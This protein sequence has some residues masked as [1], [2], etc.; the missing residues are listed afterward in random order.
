M[1][2]L[3]GTGAQWSALDQILPSSDPP[4][5]GWRRPAPGPNE[6]RADLI[7]AVA[8]ATAAV[9]TMP[10]YPWAGL[11][12]P[13][14]APLWLELLWSVAVTLP[15][16]WRRR[17]PTVI[18]IVVSAVYMAGGIAFG[19]ALFFPMIALFVAF[20]TLG[21]W[22][23]DRQRARWTRIA[24]TAAMFI[25]LIISIFV[26]ATGHRAHEPAASGPFSP[27][28]SVVLIQLFSNATF[29]LGSY[30]LGNRGY[31][32]AIDQDALERRTAELAKERE[33]STS[34]A[35]ALERIWLAREL[36][37]VVAHH[38]SVMGV[39]ASAARVAFDQNPSVA[40]QS[41]THIETSAR[42]AVEELHGLLST[43]RDAAADVS[44]HDPGPEPDT[45]AAA[46]VGIRQLP[47]LVEQAEAA[48]LPTRLE[49]I[50]DQAGLSA[51]LDVN[52]YRIVQ[53]ALTNVRKHAGPRAT[54][55]VR[56]RFYPDEVEVE[57]TN[58][59]AV[60]PPR[61]PRPGAGLGQVGMRERVA[62]SGGTIELGA[63]ARGGYLVR[64]RMPRSAAGIVSGVG[65]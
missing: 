30:Y 44:D 16:G 29:F 21:A 2:G 27:L 48:G 1:S 52:V 3:T 8:L 6:L 38:V 14:Q 59:G 4:Y 61:R 43:L 58:S 39:Q 31:A 11:V 10:L 65:S 32:Q 28:V 13:T 56:L 51:V 36:H 64:A 53:E 50:G 34:Q 12:K 55:D 26:Y 20:F 7:V 49:I 54:A 45:H 35:L 41:L 40:R 33:R 9:I 19:L 17:Y 5:P 46:T 15:V 47:A 22:E 23:P 60:P 18:A 63:L 62:A 24:I 37:D 25:W 57:I 42:T